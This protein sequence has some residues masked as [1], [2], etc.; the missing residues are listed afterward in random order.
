LWGPIEV[1]AP[2]SGNATLETF[3]M[4]DRTVWANDQGRPRSCS[5][6]A[7]IPFD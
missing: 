1:A 6:T 3:R 2:V 5:G 4:A 7:W